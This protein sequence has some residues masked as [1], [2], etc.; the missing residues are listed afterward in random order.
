[1]KPK[2]RTYSPALIIIGAVFMAIASYYCAAAMHSGET[3]FQ[4][5]DRMHRVMDAPL[6]NYL[7]AYTAK[8]F[9]VFSFVYLLLVLM[10]VTSRKNYMPGR[11]MGSA[12]YADVKKVN[13]ILADLNNNPLDPQNIVIPKHSIWQ[14]IR[15][16]LLSVR[17]DK[18]A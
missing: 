16:K 10:Y 2:K 5:A 18:A 7:N 17:R 13:K 3:I 15:W 1:M 6:Q 12:R 8:T 9:I 4:W 11:E 14:K